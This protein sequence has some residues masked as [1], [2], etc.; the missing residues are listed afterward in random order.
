MRH[1]SAPFPP[2]PVPLDDQLNSRDHLDDSSERNWKVNSSPG[3]PR[4]TPPCRQKM[5]NTTIPT[6][7]PA[8]ASW[9]D[10]LNNQSFTVTGIDGTPVTLSFADVNE[11]FYGYT[12]DGIVSGFTIGFC[13]MLFIVLLLITPPKRHRQPIFLLNII[14]LFLLVFKFIC[15]SISDCASY[16]GIGPQLLGTFYGYGKSTWIP[17][18]IG[19]IINPF[20]YATLMTSLLLQV[21]VVFVLEP[22]SQKIVTRI[23]I[24]AIVVEEGF[25]LT[26]SA[27]SILLQYDYPSVDVVPEWIYRTMRLY[28]LIFVSISCAVFLYKLA[29]TIYRRRKMGINVTKIGPMQ[30]IFIAFT[31]CLVVPSIYTNCRLN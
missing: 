13:S 18:I 17:I 10:Y 15:E 12:S 9:N 7:D 4:L 11:L 8:S 3:F 28:F 23:G 26:N 1:K 14:S 5:S 30:I 22:L 31:Q 25:C 29:L 20:L 19:C 16:S 21:R 24:I 6:P 27:F 2:F